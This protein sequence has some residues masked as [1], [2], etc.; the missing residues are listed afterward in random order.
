MWKI[1]RG[2]SRWGGFFADFQN[3]LGLSQVFGCQ[4]IQFSM[5][6]QRIGKG[7]NSFQINPL[8]SG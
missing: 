8:R 5:Q 6:L 7:T 4:M 2:F 1:E 3:L